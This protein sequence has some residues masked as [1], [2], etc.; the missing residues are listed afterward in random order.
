MQ[1][2]YQQLN[3]TVASINI[4]VKGLDSYIHI[5]GEFGTTVVFIRVIYMIGYKVFLDW[6]LWFKFDISLEQ[7]ME[8]NDNGSK[9]Y[10]VIFGWMI[11]NKQD[12]DICT[13]LWNLRKNEILD[14]GTSICLTFLF[15]TIVTHR[16]KNL[17]FNLDFILCYCIIHSFTRHATFE[18][19]DILWH[20]A[21]VFVYKVQLCST[22]TFFDMCQQKLSNREN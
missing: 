20:V 2:P 19:W 10:S 12:I 13:L 3:D 8:K 9:M 16:T 11:M 4:L 14:T 21:L 6:L 7:C 22:S 15:G 5:C 18:D 17:F 1:K